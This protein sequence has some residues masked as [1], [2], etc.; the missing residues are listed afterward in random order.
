MK[1]GG[2]GGGTA[3]NMGVPNVYGLVF[4]C[5]CGVILGVGLGANLLAFT[6][7][8]KSPRRNTLDVVLLSMALAD[9]LTLLLI[10]FTLHSALSHSWPTSDLSCK[11][12]QFLLA[13]G[14]AASTYSLCAVSVARAAVVTNPYRPLATDWAVLAL[15]LVWGLSVLVSVPLRMFATKES[16]SPDLVSFTFCLP[17][18]QEHHYQVVLSQFAL[19]Y[20]IP[21]LVIAFN[22]ARLALFLHKRPVMSASGGR[23]TRRASLTVF[24]AAATFSACWL[25]GYV[26]ELCVYLGLYRHGRAWE[27]FYFTCTLLQYLHPCVNPVL[28]VLLSKR[29]RHRRAA[30][31]FR[32]RGN[33]VRPQVSSV[34]A[35]S[36]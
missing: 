33:R 7:F 28:Y 22:Y 27:L 5:T 9:L 8:A 34:S 6:L 26:L 19:F 24:L 11:V 13:L 18:V 30:W 21:M 36:S 12:Y 14:L 31:R 32:C 25:P 29:Y 3:V 10:P 35:G 23:N 17:T 1:G 15:A 16:L 4:A 20:F 2:G